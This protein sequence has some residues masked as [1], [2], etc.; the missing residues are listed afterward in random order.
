MVHS[1]LIKFLESNKILSDFQHGFRKM[2]SGKTQLFRTTYDL[3]V[4]L[5]RWQKVDTIMLDFSKAFDKVPH[6]CLAVNSI[7]MASDTRTYPGFKVSLQ[8]GIN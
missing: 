1:H 2:G 8:I 4:G 5:D 3:A 7:T 6:H